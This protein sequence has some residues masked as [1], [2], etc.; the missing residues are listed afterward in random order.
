MAIM[1]TI[2]NKIGIYTKEQIEEVIDRYDNYTLEREKY[3]EKIKE[4]LAKI[5]ECEEDDDLRHLKERNEYLKSE[6]KRKKEFI[7]ELE[8]QGEAEYLQFL[9]DEE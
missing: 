4:C 5:K 3:K 8:K 7:D 6:I 2:L 1:I 9:F